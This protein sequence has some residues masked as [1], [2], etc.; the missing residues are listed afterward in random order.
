M[1]TSIAN[2]V[3][4]VKRHQD[5]LW[6]VFVLILIAWSGFN[7]GIISARKGAIPAQEATLFQPRTSIVSQTPSAT[8]Q[9]TTST[10]RVDKSDMRV[11]ASKGSSSKKY[12]YSWCSSGQ[13]IKEAN[14][15]WFPTAADAQK[16]GYTLAGNCSE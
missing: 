10:V 2:I 3:A 9:G 1:K 15:L 13:R 12:H 11:V 6:R 4:F 16:A 8:G 14:R 5:R 7:V